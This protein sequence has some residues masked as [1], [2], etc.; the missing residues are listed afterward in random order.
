MEEVTN[1]KMLCDKFFPENA[2]HHYVVLTDME[3][4]TFKRWQ[5][6]RLCIK[7]EEE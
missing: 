5:K 4:R 1:V 7:G 3:Y 2:P 6:D